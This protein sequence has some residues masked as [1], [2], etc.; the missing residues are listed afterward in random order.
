MH[1]TCFYWSMMAIRLVCGVQFFGSILYFLPLLH[2]Y[3]LYQSARKS[4][5]GRLFQTLFKSLLIFCIGLYPRRQPF[6]HS[7]FQTFCRRWILGVL[8][9]YD[10]ETRNVIPKKY[11]VF[12]VVLVKMLAILAEIVSIVLNNAADLI[13]SHNF[14][15]KLFTRA[16]C[17]FY[18]EMWF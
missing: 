16:K 2:T 17:D 1:H 8:N 5:M 3:F 10:D 11:L 13:S 7:F 15:P 9:F 12:F 14:Y 4:L 18:P 6:R